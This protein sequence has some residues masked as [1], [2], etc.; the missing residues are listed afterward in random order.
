MRRRTYVAMVGSAALAGCSGGP[1]ETDERE[2]TEQPTEETDSAGFQ[3]QWEVD[4]PDETVSGSDYQATS[5]AETAYLGT[6]S[7]LTAL[8]LADGTEQWTLSLDTALAAVTLDDDGLY[9]LQGTTV[10]RIDPA[11]G[12]SRWAASAGNDSVQRTDT[13]QGMVATTDDHVAAAVAAWVIVF[14]KAS[15]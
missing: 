3:K 13:N 11:T 6:K 2:P 14:E 4:L 8:A 15:G 9:T 7:E 1:G 5:D 12:E 10:Q